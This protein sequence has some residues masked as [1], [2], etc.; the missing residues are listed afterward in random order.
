M[1][2]LSQ[3]TIAEAPV[4][5][6]TPPAEKPVEKADAKTVSAPP[7]MLTISLGG[8]DSPSDAVARGDRIIPAAAD[9]VFHNRPPLYP[10][11]SVLRG[12]RG[13]VL[14][15][16]H[17][18][19]EGRTAAVDVIGGSGYPLLDRAAREAVLDWRFLPAMRGGRAVRSELPMRFIFDSE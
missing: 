2:P 1:K 10:G 3:T 5:E 18:S 15:L 17:V 7:A 6:A 14:L 12:E 19:P 11:E 8:T 16:I 4:T 13:A 9:A